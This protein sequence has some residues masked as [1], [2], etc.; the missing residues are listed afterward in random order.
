MIEVN[1]LTE[2]QQNFN[3]HS[4]AASPALILSTKLF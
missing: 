3:R 2:Q 1:K 4:N